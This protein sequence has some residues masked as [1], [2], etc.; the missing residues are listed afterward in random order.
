MNI[1]TERL[2]N[3]TVTVIN[4]LKAT[5]TGADY[6]EYIAHVCDPAMWSERV[7]RSVNSDG[8]AVSATACTAQIPASTMPYGKY[9]DYVQ[10]RGLERLTASLGDIV[11]LGRVTIPQ[12]ASRTDVLKAV[13]GLPH[14]EVQAFRD[15]S[16]NGA[17]A[18]GTGVLRYLNVLHL[19][20]SANW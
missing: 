18:N 2:L 20:G 12:G 6:D 7:Q 17:I 13:E 5:D 3:Q 19:E 16:N 1:D 11:A 8:T 4:C 15:L 9:I 14:F 10:N